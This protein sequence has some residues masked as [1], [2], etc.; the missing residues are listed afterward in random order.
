MCP[1]II[2]T[3]FELIFPLHEFISKSH[4]PLLAVGESHHP[5]RVEHWYFSTWRPELIVVT[6]ALSDKEMSEVFAIFYKISKQYSI[7]F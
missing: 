5:M 3:L 6:V 4:M 2:Y 7:S 1:I